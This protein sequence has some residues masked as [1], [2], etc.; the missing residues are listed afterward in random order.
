MAGKGLSMLAG[1]LVIALLTRY[2]SKDDWAAYIT[3]TSFLSFFAVFVDF[4]LTLTLTQ[5][6]SLAGVDEKKI[7]G[8]I[9]G[10]RLASGFVFYTLSTIVVTLLPYS[11]MTKAGVA[12][13]AA[14]FF[15]M[16]AAGSMVGLFQKHLAMRRYVVAEMVSRG[17]YL[18]LTFLCVVFGLGLLPI[19][20][21]MGLANGLWFLFV[22]IAAKPLTV[23]RPRFDWVV[24][25]DA[26]HRSAPIAIS[27]IFN[28]IYLRGDVLILAWA[29]PDDVAQYG[30][31]YKVVD[32]M[33]AF[34][35]MFM[36]L[37]LPQ[38]AMAWSE[39][40]QEHFKNILQKAFNLFSLVA[41][42]I[43]FGT[44]IVA[45]PLTE[46]IAGSRYAAAGLILQVL[47][48]AIICV[49]VS[50]LYGHTI[51]ALHKQKI[52][53]WGY[54]ITAMVA[55]IGYFIF[56]PRYGMWGAAG[57]TCFSEFLIAALTFVVVSR[58]SKT[59]PNLMVA[60][61]ATLAGLVMYFILSTLPTWPVLITI[62][63]GAIIYGIIIVAIGGIN[64]K[65]IK[66]LMTS[67]PTQS[68]APRP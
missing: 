59:L 8:S 32:V 27:T 3:A 18:I 34:P 51:V 64:L 33:T 12:A 48:F 47:I 50:T 31:A 2:L 19:L 41:I 52:M 44:Q 55:I 57:V 17:L 11:D 25:K 65:E 13:G 68:V 61:K 22:V 9:M 26:F 24:W 42:P 37:L 16:S 38:L 39:K 29:R 62:S 58:V 66:S 4:G 60:A 20:G 6:I 46:L 53:T 30:T 28:L 15:F 7:I 56:I 43:F 63:L 21:A 40:N 10:I 36:G 35:T 45:V 67:A 1:L 49:F 54:A 14:A 23:I 5:M